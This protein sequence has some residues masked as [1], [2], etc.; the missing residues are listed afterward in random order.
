MCYFTFYK[1]FFCW[2]LAQLSCSL[3]CCGFLQDVYTMML[4]KELSGLSKQDQFYGG[5]NATLFK[6]ARNANPIMDTS[7]HSRVNQ[8]GQ[9]TS[10]LI[11]DWGSRC[12]VCNALF[13]TRSIM[14]EHK[15]GMHERRKYVCLC[16]RRFKWRSSLATHRPRCMHQAR[17][18][19]EMHSPPDIWNLRCRLRLRDERKYMYWFCIASARRVIFISS[20]TFQF[21]P[22]YK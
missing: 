8:R 3:I 10:Q 5:S 21:F 1:S 18:I 15:K 9:Q 4:S 14:V 19:K 11:G 13:S 2:C 20:Y 22:V 17:A 7:V 12:D 6:G 16:G